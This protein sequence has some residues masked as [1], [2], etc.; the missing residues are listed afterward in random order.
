MQTPH[1]RRQSRL[2][3][4]FLPPSSVMIVSGKKAQTTSPVADGATVGSYSRHTPRAPP[5]LANRQHSGRGKGQQKRT[6]AH[7]HTQTQPEKAR[8]IAD[9]SE[10]IILGRCPGCLACGRSG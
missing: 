7:T 10:H 3:V 8:A 6:H 2:T 9:M 4:S 1:K 5:C